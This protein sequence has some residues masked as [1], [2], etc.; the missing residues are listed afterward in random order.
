M[1]I[2]K[3][4][5][6]SGYMFES[7]LEAGLVDG[8]G[9][10][11]QPRHQLRRRQLGLEG[12]HPVEQHQGLPCN[13]PGQLLEL[14]VQAGQVLPREAA[15]PLQE[16]LAEVTGF[17]AQI[18]VGQPAVHRQGAF[19]RGPVGGGLQEKEVVH[20]FLV[21]PVTLGLRGAG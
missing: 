21:G 14:P 10:I 9:Q 20:H 12:Q 2:G 8:A 15:V 17:P 7:A 3:D 11:E 18:L 4:T 1:V 5:R 19:F 16:S 6:I 13:R